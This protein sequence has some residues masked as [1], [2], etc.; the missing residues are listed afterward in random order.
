MTRLVVAGVPQIFVRDLVYGAVAA[1]AIG[2]VA[3]ITL[4]NFG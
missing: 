1:F 3:Y 2:F 4:F